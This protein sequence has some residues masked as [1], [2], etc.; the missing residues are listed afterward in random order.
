MIR[1]SGIQNRVFYYAADSAAG[2]SVA[3]YRVPMPSKATKFQLTNENTNDDGTEFADTIMYVAAG[4]G[5]G[6]NTME[7]Q[8][9]E[10]AGC[11][12]RTQ[13]MEIIRHHADFLGALMEKMKAV[14]KVGS[15][16]SRGILQNDSFLIDAQ[17]DKAAAD[18]FRFADSFVRTLSA[19]GNAEGLWI[20]L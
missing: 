13:D 18:T 1:K 11:P 2:K 8:I 10:F 16:I 15:G 9:A 7:M 14:D 19:G 4:R 6:G 12:K 3:E 5:S 17:H 20:I